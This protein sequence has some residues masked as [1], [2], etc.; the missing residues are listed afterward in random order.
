M[1]SSTLI[2]CAAILLAGVPFGSA[3]A[4]DGPAEPSKAIKYS[5]LNLNTSVG[6]AALYQ[7]IERAASEVCQLPQGTKQLKIESEIKACRADSVDRAIVQ[8]NL[9]ALSAL[10]VA[11][12]GRKLDSAQ[13]ANRR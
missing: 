2:R 12:T 5:D 11:R 3:L 7:R 9:P 8:V 1:T 10:H 6:V 4:A 13:Y